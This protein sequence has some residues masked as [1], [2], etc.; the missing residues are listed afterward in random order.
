M[1]QQQPVT[2]QPE[3]VPMGE[4]KVQENGKIVHFHATKSPTEVRKE[5]T[6]QVKDVGASLPSPD[7]G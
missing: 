5:A 7:S 1:Y 2:Y 4:D 6:Q 3:V